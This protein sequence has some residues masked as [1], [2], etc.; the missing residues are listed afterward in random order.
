LSDQELEQWVEQLLTL[1]DENERMTEKQLNIM[2]AA[3]E[4]FS[5]KGYAAASTSEIAQKAGVAEGTIFRHYKTKK[6]LLLSIVV[7]LMTRLVGP[8]VIRDFTK[9]I[10]APYPRLEDFLRAVI[11]NRYEFAKSHLPMLKI[12]IQEIPFHPELR[13]QFFEHVGKKV[14]A[15]I[16]TVLRQF[17]ADGQLV[18]APPNSVIRFAI[19]SVFGLILSRLLLFPELDWDDEKEVEQTIQFLLH[20]ISG[21]SH[22]DAQ[23]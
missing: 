11:Y 2:K 16:Q 18:D 23:K 21:N 7:P 1:G 6:E 12:L 8:F 5:E 10:D 20:G 14:I 9:V 22:T 4:I 3:V 13:E 15:R 17:Q 19:S